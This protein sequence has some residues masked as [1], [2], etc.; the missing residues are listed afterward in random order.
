MPMAM[1]MTELIL[2]LPLMHERLSRSQPRSMASLGGMQSR[3]SG[4]IGFNGSRGSEW[5]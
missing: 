3:G 1:A 4:S 2:G 5:Q